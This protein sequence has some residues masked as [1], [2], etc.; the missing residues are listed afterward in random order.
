MRSLFAL[1][2]LTLVATTV[3]T[4]PASAAG[5]FNVLVFSKVVGFVH[6][7]IPAGK[8]ALEQLGADND[9]DVTVTDDASVFTDA[10][11]APYD[12]V[13]FNNTNS[14]DGAI[15]DANQRAAFERFIRAGGG[16]TGIHSASG[17]E[18][19]WVWYHDLLGATFKSHPAVQNVTIEVDDRVHP[20]TKDLPQKWDRNEEPYDFTANPRGN[21]HV[22]ASFDTRG[23]GG[24]TMGA[25]HPI[26]WCQEFDGGRSW[27]TGLGHNPTAFQEP[28]FLEHLLGGIEWAAGAVA[29]DCGATEN[30][31]YEKVQLDGNTDDPLD[32]DID[33]LGRVFLVERGGAV[34]VYDPQLQSTKE[35][36]KFSVLVQHTHGMHGI[37]LDPNFATNKYM[38]IYY[39]PLTPEVSRVSRFTY[40]ETTDVVD[41]ASE[42]VLLSFNAQRTQNAHEGG[43]LAFDTNGNLYVGTGDNSSPCCSGFGPIDERAGY[44]YND[45]QRS[46]GNT[47]DLRGKVLRIHPEANGT[48][49]IPAG[50]LFAPGTAK[51]RPEIYVM[52][53]RQP[54]RIAVDPETNYLYWGEVGPDA[55]ADSTT[56]GPMGHD[57]FNQAKTAGNYG[58]PY[59]I[60]DN[61]PYIDYNFAT[62]VSGAAFDCANGPT[63]NSP[64]NTGLTT[65]PAA[66]AAWIPYVYGETPL[67][68]ELGSGG[69]M[70][71]G[72]PS[73][74]YDATSTSAS[75]FPAY[76]DDATFIA[77]W[78]RNTIFEV[79]KDAT[80]KPFSINRFLPSMQFLRPID[81][82]FGPDGS[83][84]VIEWGTNYGGSGRGDPNLDSG[85]YKINYSASGKRAPVAKGSA[86]PTN[87]RAP[88]TVAFSS[89]GSSDPDAD[90][91]TFGWDFTNNGS[92]DS[93]AANP[94]FTYTTNGNHTAR[95]V[96]TDSTGRTDVVNI[97][98]TVGNTAPTVTLNG[99]QDGQIFEFGSPI[100]YSVKVTD[101]EDGPINCAS[102]TT[103]PALGHAQ[104]AHP[105]DNSYGCGGT[106]TAIVDDGHT[107]NDNLFYVIDTKYTDR[108]ANGVAALTAGDSAVLQP[109]HKEADHFTR[110]S[111]TNLFDTISG[112]PASGKII[113]NVSNNDW[114]SFEPVNLYG[115]DKMK[116]R[117]ASGSSGGTIEIRKGSTTGTLIGSVAVPVTGG[118]R[119]WTEV[120]A[121]I[122]DPG[123]SYEMFVV[124][125]NSTTTGDLLNVDW[126]EFQK[127]L[128]EVTKVTAPTPVTGGVQTSATVTVANNKPTAVTTVV[129]LT[130][131]SGWTSTPTSVTVPANTT[132]DFAIPFR[133]S[134]TLTAGYVELETITAKAGNAAGTPVASTYRVLDPATV[135]KAIDAGSATSPLF[136][137]YARLSPATAYAD[138]A[139][140]GWTGTNT[141]LSDRDRGAPDALRRDFVTAQSPATLRLKV[142]AGTHTV[143]VLRGDQNYSAQPLLV[144]LGTTRLLNGGKSLG[145]GQFAW[146]S[147]T[148]NGGTSG[149][150]VDLKFSTSTANEWWRFNA[151]VIQ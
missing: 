18:Y 96:V 81:M 136:G 85:V 24:D 126:M 128:V 125:K 119:T 68:P 77:D 122:T 150:T 22:L 28:L 139:G 7:S 109:K 110:Q 49:T 52:G 42:K 104:H 101:P 92:I 129:S 39:S 86:T 46:S 137:G 90:A 74:H 130:V 1:L 82:E 146:E 37:V 147:F 103:T 58:W 144:D 38:Y 8:A 10:G 21:V 14:R 91:I 11:L 93:T 100:S 48:Y 62:G 47:N 27:Y 43:G 15:L 64:N 32:M 41:M 50:N 131:P 135:T 31:R 89:A 138:A 132:M 69:R 148:V 108:G 23:Y 51:T 76:Y 19:D 9:F 36:A 13:V 142:P 116:F 55:Q 65:L 70:A 40:N 16:W 53:V 98:I 34:K 67:W 6:D 113:G 56:R 145:A 63:N 45:A 4:A 123:G 121:D 112:D 35:A 134:N 97:P 17:S 71:V 12:A 111:G 80:G 88:L 66:R 3:M 72:G 78:T 59:C 102:V 57:E 2:C 5:R 99:P 20:S 107:S 87:G 44:E 95:L 25:D 140:F 127:E 149:T 141:G 117:V 114:I 115:I 61:K 124:F 75:K 151:L 26:S 133:P 106:I 84:Y 143:W 29:G 30:S 120:T 79:K 60:G 54:Y 83:M 105:L 118:W 73:Y 94:S 33:S